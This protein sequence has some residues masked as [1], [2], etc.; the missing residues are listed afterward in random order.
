MALRR[1]DAV[2]GVRKFEHLTAVQ[3]SKLK[4]PIADSHRIAQT[5]KTHERLAES[6]V[7]A[8]IVL[9]CAVPDQLLL[10]LCARSPAKPHSLSETFPGWLTLYLSACPGL[11]SYTRRDRRPAR[12]EQAPASRSAAGLS[13]P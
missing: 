10:G 5:S 12:S 8:K 6:K 3:A 1:Y 11:A 2:A 4:V 9:A 7:L 13:T